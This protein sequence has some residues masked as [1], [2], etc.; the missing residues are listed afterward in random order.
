MLKMNK[1]KMYIKDS[2][3]FLVLLMMKYSFLAN[4]EM[5]Y[6]RKLKQCLSQNLMNR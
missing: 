2:S 4:K 5:I 3:D 6:K 1:A